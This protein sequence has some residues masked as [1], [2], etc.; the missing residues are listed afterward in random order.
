MAAS[1]ITLKS[2]T[3]TDFTGPK[4]NGKRC[5]Y[6]VVAK[7][8]GKTPSD[9]YQAV[10]P[11][12]MGWKVEWDDSA[13]FPMMLKQYEF[14]DPTFCSGE[15]EVKANFTGTGKQ[16]FICIY[17]GCEK[18]SIPPDLETLKK[19]PETYFSPDRSWEHLEWHAIYGEATKDGITYADNE[20]KRNNGPLSSDKWLVVW[21][22]T[23]PKQP[24]KRKF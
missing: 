22:R 5:G 11:Q 12:L 13:L 19:A 17:M 14:A 21:S 3:V 18:K 1:S 8:E 16:L 24:V 9:I 2:L 15:K 23:K 6:E 20:N 4:G 10:M 7:A